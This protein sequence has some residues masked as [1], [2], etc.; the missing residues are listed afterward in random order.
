MRIERE[1]PLATSSPEMS[2][3]IVTPDSYEVIRKTIRHLRKQTVRERLEIVIVAPSRAELQLMDSDL[4]G[5]HSYKIVEVGQIRILSNAKAAAIPE[6]S[7]PVVAFAED[8]CF[9]ECDWAEALIKA[10]SYGHAAVGPIMRN[11]NPTT[12]LSWAGLFLH[13]GC[14][15][16]PLLSG[17][18]TNL[19]W[20]NTSF[21]R[22]LLLEY[23]SELAPM[24][25]VEGILFDDLRSKGHT[26]HLEPAARTHHVNI[27]ILSSWIAHAFWGGRLF[28][29]LR[30]KKNEWS[31][32][33]RLAYIGALPLIPAVRFYRTIGIVQRTAK[34]SL[35]FRVI[36]FL[37][38]GLLPHALGEVVGYALGVGNTAERYSYY[39]TKRILH[40]TQADREIFVM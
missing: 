21:K 36:P 11:A 4:Q 26:L 30:A 1:K 23:C 40:V 13:Y 24:L 18:Y 20:H 2:V 5:F 29:A 12:A 10:H 8:H 15:L 31:V 27:S 25:L 28:G 37:L 16:Q 9:P 33:K 22:H 35:L 19:P 34:H 3:V 14:C 17:Q 6:T 7:A 39:E 32:F 38:S